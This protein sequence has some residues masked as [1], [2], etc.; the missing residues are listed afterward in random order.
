MGDFISFLLGLIGLYIA[1]RIT[2]TPMQILD[3][4][5][6][7]GQLREEADRRIVA[8]LSLIARGERPLPQ[9]DDSASRLQALADAKAIGSDSSSKFG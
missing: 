9:C 5:K 2:M 7:Q 4:L 8:L 3:E 1:V 6:R